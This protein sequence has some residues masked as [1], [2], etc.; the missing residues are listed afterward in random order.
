MDVYFWIA[1]DLGI[2]PTEI[3]YVTFNSKCKLID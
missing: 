3:K 2:K 1:H